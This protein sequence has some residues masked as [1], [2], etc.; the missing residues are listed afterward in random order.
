MK[1]LLIVTWQFIF[2][3]GKIRRDLFGYSVLFLL[4]FLPF[5][6]WKLITN[7]IRAAEEER[8][9][10][11]VYDV[12]KFHWAQIMNRYGVKT[13]EF[14]LRRFEN[15]LIRYKGRVQEIINHSTWWSSWKNQVLVEYTVPEGLAPTGVL[16]PSGT[17][18]YLPEEELASFP[19]RF[20]ERQLLEGEI[21]QEVSDVREK[22]QAGEVYE[23]SDLFSWIEVVNPEGV[24]NFGYR[25]T[26]LDVCGI[27]AL[28]SAQMIGPTSFGDL[29]E[30]TPP[31]DGEFLG[32][33]IPCPAHTLFFIGEN[34]TLGR[35]PTGAEGP[36]KWRATA[37]PALAKNRL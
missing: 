16:C 27:E 5:G 12:P 4:L 36:L 6:G 11:A 23:V 2:P 15:C 13:E 14:Q 30:Y 8:V 21:I 26:F 33:G 24:R 9:Y 22:K 37:F 34:H 20:R 3:L 19:D 25:V 35:L 18:Y 32:I 17:V 10:G 1:R 28:G 7:E 29:F 31:R